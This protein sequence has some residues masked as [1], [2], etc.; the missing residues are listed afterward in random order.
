[1]IRIRGT[2]RISLQVIGIRGTWRISLQ[3][4]GIRG[5]MYMTYLIASDIITPGTD[6]A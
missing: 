6:Q 4:I 1:V 2:W 5:T 3:V